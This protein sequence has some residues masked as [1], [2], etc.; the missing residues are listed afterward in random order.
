[1]QNRA[2]KGVY[3]WLGEL[4][5]T[6]EV[7]TR[8]HSETRI[9]TTIFGLLFWDIIFADV[10][11]AFET[12]FQTAPLDIAEDSFY[13]ARKELIQAW[14]RDIEDGKAAEI[15]ECHEWEYP[16]EDLLEIVQVHYWS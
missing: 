2:I 3:S 14:L 7:L 10:P 8:F 11:G 16:K 13:Y 5:N 9:L 4:L 6:T 12:K 1:M 15:M